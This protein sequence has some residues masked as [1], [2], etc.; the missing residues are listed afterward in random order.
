[1]VLKWNTY[2]WI[3]TYGIQMNTYFYECIWNAYG[4]PM[5]SLRMPMEPLC[6]YGYLRIPMESLRMTM[7]LLWN[8]YVPTGTYG[9]PMNT[10]ETPMYLRVPTEPLRIPME[11][12]RNAYV[13]PRS[14][15]E[16][17]RNTYGILTETLV[18]LWNSY[19][20]GTYGHLGIPPTEYLWISTYLWT[21]RHVLTEYGGNRPPMN[22]M[23][24][25]KWMILWMK[26]KIK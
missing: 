5:E 18:H 7:E 15:Y 24:K 13:S 9:T 14:S 21:Y 6:T 22:I 8:P 19:T 16:S 11:W 17:L 26:K 23:K 12:L 1:M 4:I 10:Y 2:V 25:M 20:Y 3:P